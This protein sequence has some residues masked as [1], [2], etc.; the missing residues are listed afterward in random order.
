MQKCIRC[1]KMFE[2]KHENLNELNVRVWCNSCVDEEWK[3]KKLN[4]KESAL[5]SAFL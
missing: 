5:L 3:N 2:D 4:H 1:G